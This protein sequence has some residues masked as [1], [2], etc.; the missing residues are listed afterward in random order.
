MDLYVMEQKEFD[1]LIERANK[2]IMEMDKAL[3]D[4]ENAFEQLKKEIYELYKQ[5]DNGKRRFD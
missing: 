2:S 5:I 1:D 4:S 3:M